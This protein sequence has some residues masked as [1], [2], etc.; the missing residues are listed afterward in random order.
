MRGS[1]A[2][3][4]MALHMSDICITGD[5]DGGG[6]V[7]PAEKK[8]NYDSTPFTPPHKVRHLRE[9][10]VKKVVKE[11]CVAV[12]FSPTTGFHYIVG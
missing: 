4:Q 10:V 2:L 8:T 5:R 1:E 6:L 7:V 11:T 12:H 3:C 9:V